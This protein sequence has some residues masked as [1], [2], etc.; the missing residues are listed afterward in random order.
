MKVS[1]A[2][3]LAAAEPGNYFGNMLAAKHL[4]KSIRQ[5]ELVRDPAPCP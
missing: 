3:A 1:G 2:A 4:S 5:I